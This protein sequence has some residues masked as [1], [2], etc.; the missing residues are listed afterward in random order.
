[1]YQDRYRNRHM[2]FIWSSW[3]ASGAPSLNHQHYE[4]P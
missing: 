2:K 4:K 1:M 3:G